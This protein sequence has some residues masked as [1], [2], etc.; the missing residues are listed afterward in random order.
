MT[1]VLPARTTT[2]AGLPLFESADADFARHYAE[3]GFALL[4]RRLEPERGRGDQRR[5]RA[6]VPRRVRRDS[7]RLSGRRAGRRQPG[8]SAIGLGRGTAPGVPLHPLPAQGVGGCAGG[9]ART[10]D[11]RGPGSG[12]RAERQGHAVDAVHQVGGQAGSGVAPGR[13]LH[14]DPRPVAD[15]GLDRPGR[16]DHRERLPVGA[17]R[18]APAGRDLPRPGAG[19]SPLRLHHRVLRLPVLRRA[20]GAGAR[21]RRARR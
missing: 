12:D 2:P 15:G 5:R 20:G 11:R 8:Y 4:G 6:P 16:R 9:A 7:L 19:R 3:H 13:V 18:L 10:A 21:S 1:A 14:P 17:A